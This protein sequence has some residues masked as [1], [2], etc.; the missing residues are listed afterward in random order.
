MP[1][2]RTAGHDSLKRI[3]TLIS[4]ARER[5]LDD[6]RARWLMLMQDMPLIDY[7]SIS[8]YIL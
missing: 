7:I 5:G 2:K 8:H 3:I 6:D 1:P 4:W